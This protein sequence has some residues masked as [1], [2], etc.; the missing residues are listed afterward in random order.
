MIQ[1]YSSKND[2]KSN[3]IEHSVLWGH[4][5][6]CNLMR[7]LLPN[8]LLLVGPLLTCAEPLGEEEHPVRTRLDVPD[9]PLKPGPWPVSRRVVEGV[10]ERNL[11]VEVWYPGQRGSEVSKRGWLRSGGSAQPQRCLQAGLN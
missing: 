2:N 6:A 4:V 1:L 7:R 10:T 5:M 3:S 11:T 8:V 9:D